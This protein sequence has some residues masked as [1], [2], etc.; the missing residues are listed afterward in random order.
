MAKQKSGGEGRLESVGD[1][2]AASLKSMKIG[3]EFRQHLVVYQW[4][5]LVGKDIANH[6][7]AVKLE[8][9]RLFVRTSHPAWSE[10]LKYMEAELKRRINSHFGEELV[11]EIVFTN[12]SC[13]YAVRRE[14]PGRENEQENLGI[15]LRK[16]RLADAELEA[17]RKACAA[18]ED[19]E[20]RRQAERLGCNVHRM[21][22][23][24]RMSGWHGC[25]ADGC[26]GSC[27][28]EEE[29]CQSCRRRLRRQRA[30]RIQ[31]LLLDMPWAR[32]GDILQ[33]LECS[34]QEFKEQRMILIQ[35]LAG[36][37]DYG[38]VESIE[39]RTLVMLYR[40]IPPEQLND[41]VVKKTMS[42]L[43]RDVRYVPGKVRKD[44]SGE[45]VR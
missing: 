26:S 38:D 20:L 19:D 18:I 34:E 1:I 2:L 29:Y 42:R 4:P 28:P 44:S 7:V 24:R 27:E 45:A 21:L 37:V 30:D 10:Q 3:K 13:G 5:A 32:Y 39:A 9:K 16:I 41:E 25:A 31:Q 22:H 36:S 6:A 23:Y 33:E 11:R 14:E 43:R 8:F 12:Q 40:S 35:R 15:Q 17:I